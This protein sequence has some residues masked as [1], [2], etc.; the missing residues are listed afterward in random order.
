MRWL[1]HD[2]IIEGTTNDATLEDRWRESCCPLTIAEGTPDLRFHIDLVNTVPTPPEVEPLFVQQDLFSYYIWKSRIHIHFP[3]FGHLVLDLEEGVT[4]GAVV[5]FSLATHGLLEDIVAS[6]LSPHLRRRG[7]FMIHAFAAS[8]DGHFALLVG[9]IGAGK[10][11]TGIALIDSG[12]KLMS[13]DSP[14]IAL[15]GRAL[16]Y[17]GYVAAY[18]DTLAMFES[19]RKLIEEVEDNKQKIEFSAGDLWP[20]VWQHESTSGVI[21]FPQI[22]D[23]G[24]HVLEPLSKAEALGRLLPHT[25]DSWDEKMQESHLKAME[26]LV[27][28]SE[29]YLLRLGRDSKSLPDI[30][31]A[32]LARSD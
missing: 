11:T 30:I 21:L 18:P 29:A 6:G 7:L 2:L 1:L 14:I 24:Q 9:D 16:S 13:N 28:A 19:T 23:V 17:P 27:E 3:G 20:N 12:W 32:T 31:A 22:Q 4:R 25:I 8:K 10:T 15:D 5:P 26:E